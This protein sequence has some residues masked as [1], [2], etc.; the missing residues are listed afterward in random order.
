MNPPKWH[1]EVHP[2]STLKPHPKNPR[3]LSKD[4]FRQLKQSIQKFGYI[5]KVVINTD[6]T[7]IGGHQRIQ[8]MKDLKV[9]TV[10]CEVPDR[11][12]DED[13]V[14]EILIRLN[15][16]HGSFD[17]D[18]LANEFDLSKLLDYGFPMEE[19]ELIEPKEIDSEKEDKKKK[20]KTCP[21]C[22]YES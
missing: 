17:Y 9:K 2:I 8:V 6:K 12:L 21:K 4:Q 22:G 11:L 3:Q 10:E 1:I 7:I 18:K 5:E 14:E 13:E 20:L 16:N 15:R 19:L